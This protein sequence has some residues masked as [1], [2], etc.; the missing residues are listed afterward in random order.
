M[1][2]E[3]LRAKVLETANRMLT[4]GVVHGSQGNVSARDSE[5]GWIAITP[6]AIPYPQLTPEEI[7]VIDETGNI[8]DAAW[9]PTSERLMHLAIYQRRPDVQAIVH[10]HA[11]YS[12]VFGIIDLPLEPILTEAAMCIGGAVPVAAYDRPG[13]QELA[14]HTADVLAGCSSVIMAH[15]GLVTVGRNLDEAYDT[16]MA[17][18][19]SARVIIM[20]KSMGVPYRVLPESEAEIMHGIYLNHYHPSKIDSSASR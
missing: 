13:T 15:H 9:K 10:S 3:N 8:I 1:I 4:D 19:T 14:D 11:L 20:A 7:C 17:V 5:T 16:T 2:L 6:S 12:S 18:D